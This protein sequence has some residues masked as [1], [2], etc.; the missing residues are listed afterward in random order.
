[1]SQQKQ[2]ISIHAPK[3]QKSQTN[4]QLGYFLAGLIDANSRINIL[5]PQ[6]V[7]STKGSNFSYKNRIQ[8]II[9]FD[10]K[11]ISVAYYIKKM[12]GY[13]SVKKVK[14]KTGL[15]CSYTI[16]HLKGI[17]IIT[18]LVHNKLKAIS[19][20]NQFNSVLSSLALDNAGKEVTLACKTTPVALSNQGT[21]NNCIDLNNHWLAGFIQGSGDFQIQINHS[22]SYL[23][24][25]KQAPFGPLPDFQESQVRSKDPK[26]T[27]VYPL[28][29]IVVQISQKDSV[30]LKQIQLTFGGRIDYCKTQETYNYSSVN[31]YNTV[32]F[33][34][35][36]DPYQV[37]GSCLTAYWV[38]RK[39]YLRVQ[40][41]L[42]KDFA[43]GEQG[44]NTHLFIEE[45]EL[46]EIVSFKTTISK[47]TKSS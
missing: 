38:W 45:K 19:K 34:Q 24:V 6:L 7:Q 47:L 42:I 12:I 16:D 30:L 17:Q 9:I 21:D 18:D 20:I 40:P 10:Q 15:F 43:L 2:Q 36:L 13:G 37:M 39:A 44:N 25:F 27:T 29:M 1:M 22:C 5:N 46:S 11:D 31:S 4:K 33:I 23:N 14:E 8:I 28:V 35:Y 26:K 32:K 41:S 3:A